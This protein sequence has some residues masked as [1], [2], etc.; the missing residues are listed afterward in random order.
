MNPFKIA[1]T[2]VWLLCLAAFFVAV[3]SAASGYGRTLFW[4]LSVVHLLECGFFMRQL[5]E[6]PGSL[7]SHLVQTFLFGFVH[8]SQVRAKSESS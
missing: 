2:I 1:L 7:G 8:I 6:A 5:R 3:D 4:G